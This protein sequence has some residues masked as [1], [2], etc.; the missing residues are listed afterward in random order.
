MPAAGKP[1]ILLVE[2]E[3]SIAEPFA[4]ALQRVLWLVKEVRHSAVVS[5]VGME[6]LQQPQDLGASTR[7]K[8]RESFWID[9]PQTRVE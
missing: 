1:T 9:G 6:E 8:T 5:S 4:S 2:D 3:R 7:M